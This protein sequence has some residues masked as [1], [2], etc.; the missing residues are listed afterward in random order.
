MTLLLLLLLLIGLLGL[1]VWCV[2]PWG[3]SVRPQ[4]RACSVFFF[5]F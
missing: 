1:E 2:A 5:F 4:A 3:D